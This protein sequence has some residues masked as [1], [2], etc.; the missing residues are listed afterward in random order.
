MFR[1]DQP[2]ISPADDL[3][4]RDSFARSLAEAILNYDSS[5]NLVIGLFGEWG[6][7]KTSVI[8]MVAGYL[9]SLPSPENIAPIVTKFNPWNFS[10][11]NQLVGEFFRH[12]SHVLEKPDYAGKTKEAGEKLSLYSKF[13]SP[14]KFVPG[15]GQYTDAIQDLLQSAGASATSFGEAMKHDITATRN[16][17]NTI[18]VELPYKIII[19]IDDID[20]LN[21]AEIRQIFQLVK[22]LADFPNTIYLLAFDKEVILRALE[23]VQEGPGF[24]YL[25]KVI[26]VPFEIPPI[27]QSELEALFFS[28]LDEIIEFPE[29]EWDQTHW[30][31][32]YHS[33][34][35]HLIK[36]IRDVNRF[37]NVLRFGYKAVKGKVNPVDLIA[38]TAIQVFTPD[39]YSG[40]RD[41][42]DLFA[43]VWG[44]SSYGRNDSLREQARARC[45]TLIDAVKKFEPEITKDF[46][47]RLFPRLEAIYQ[48]TYYDHG[49]L[50]S[51]RR[52]GRAC[53]PDNFD[54]FFRLSIPKGEISRAEMKSIIAEAKDAGSFS[55]ALLA[56][57]KDGRITRFLNLLEDYTETEIPIE[58]IESIISSLIDIGDSFPEGE[59][60]FHLLNNRIRVRR[61]ILQLLKRIDRQEDRFSMLK[62]A[63]DLASH[64]IET[65]LGVLYNL[66]S[67]HGRAG[68]KK[69]LKPEENRRVSAIQLDQLEEIAVKK[70]HLWAG[71][72]KLSG[73]EQLEGILFS[74]R[75]LEGSQPVQQFIS[76]LIESDD[77]FIDFISCFLKK[78]FSHGASDHVAKMEWTVDLKAVGEFTPVQEASVRAREFSVSPQFDLLNEHKKLAIQIFLD[79]VDGKIDGEF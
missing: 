52:S 59:T 29:E 53:S 12:L 5:D 62:K 67:D 17:L 18:L 38:L 15:I 42:K 25:E 43:G 58:N 60:G 70:L 73:H 14:L 50:A 3:L 33:G 16:E 69:D 9:Q 26:Q 37:V 32:L 31:N 2:I 72:G 77:G 75:G 57:N 68:S 34:I 55:L 10:D 46:L 22:T 76:G 54:I 65:I 48:N 64:S 51:W 1:G 44:S 35:K 45:D 6:S 23:K 8:N 28:K 74:W 20:R 7:G 11:Q 4:G 61:I 56:L 79:T 71:E 36:N 19:V 41:N 49:E 47:Q 66:L 30:G 27:S 39:L 78:R 24:E 40:I 13:F 21:N 63:M